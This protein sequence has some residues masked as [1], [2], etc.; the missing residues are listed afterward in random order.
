MTPIT[1][2]GSE[3]IRVFDVHGN[4]LEATFPKRAKGLVK[5]GRA[6]WLGSVNH[7]DPEFV[8]DSIIFYD[9]LPADLMPRTADNQHQTEVQSMFFFNNNNNEYNPDTNPEISETSPE[10]KAPETID[11]AI[12]K[13]IDDFKSA[14]AK[15]REEAETALHNIDETIKSSGVKEDAESLLHKTKAAIKD[16][17]HSVADAFAAKKEEAASAFDTDF[18]DKDDEEV[19]FPDFGEIP[20][21]AES[22]VP[23]TS[24][25]KR[26][27][28]L[29]RNAQSMM[30]D[31]ANTSIKSDDLDIA[32][33]EANNLKIQSENVS[34]MY[35]QTLDAME[36]QRKEKA[37]SAVYERKQKL[38]EERI[39]KLEED[40]ARQIKT[41]GKLFEDQ[42]INADQ[43]IGEINSTTRFYN[44]EI[45]KLIAMMN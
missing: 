27:D 41:M 18:A 16:A 31:V 32:N 22:D 7:D 4:E 13:M 35:R 39:A 36:Q 43:L 8:P 10:T 19:A 40:K 23:E 30:N 25:E 26:F 3:M 6:Q 44:D 1:K 28:A 2:N 5:K 15:A 29:L 34:E 11:P 14:M 9:T 17:Y 20:E 42:L 38:L 24:D 45:N 12:L 21:A 33:V 37:Q